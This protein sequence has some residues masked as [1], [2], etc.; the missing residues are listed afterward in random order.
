[1]VT[2]VSTLKSTIALQ[3]E[4]TS[5]LEIALSSLKFNLTYESL[6]SDSQEGSSDIEKEDL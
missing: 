4:T 3:Q 1:M 5:Q 2:K 6:G